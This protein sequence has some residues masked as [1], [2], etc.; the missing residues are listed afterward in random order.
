MLMTDSGPK[1]AMLLAAGLGKRMGPLTIKTPKPLITIGGYALID[2][3]IDHSVN[4]G[5]DKI[6]INIHHLGS[7]I[8]QHV[9]NR[10]NLKIIFSDETKELLETGGGIVKALSHL[11]NSP[12]FVI[13]GDVL[14]VDGPKASLDRLAQFWNDEI[15]DGLLLLH[16]TV[17]SYGYEG[18]GDFLIDPNGI[19][20]R[21]PELLVSPYVYTGIQLLHPRLFED[22][23]NGPFSLNQLYSSSMEKGRLYGI[24]HDGDWFHVGT[25][26]GLNQ[27]EAF[28]QERFPGLRHR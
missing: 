8:V 25:P 4:V 17:E 6:V 5:V 28:F 21:R 19:L 15:M 16:S 3:A 2:Y 24:I 26:I 20:T 22:V 14:W 9:R 12:F 18:F 23:P 1:T 13:N 7:Q 11:G 27:A 10:K